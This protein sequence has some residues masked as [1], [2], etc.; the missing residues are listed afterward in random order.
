[1]WRDVLGRRGDLVWLLVR[2]EVERGGGGLTASAL[3]RSRRLAI[4]REG[5]TERVRR[6]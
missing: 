1:V 4:I 3:E 6:R 2:A 5:G